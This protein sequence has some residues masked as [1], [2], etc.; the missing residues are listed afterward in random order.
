MGYRSVVISSAVHISVKNRQLIISGEATGSIPVE[1]IRTLMIESRAATI[2][3]YALSELSDNGV[4]VYLCDEKHLPSAVL[5]PFC[6]YSRQRK[7]LT[8]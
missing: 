4:C 8:L 3:S 5:Q 6:R 1:D 7:Q 2:T